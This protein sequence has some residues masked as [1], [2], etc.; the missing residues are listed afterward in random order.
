MSEKFI[1][2]RGGCVKGRIVTDGDEKHVYDVGG[3]RL[4]FTRNG[5]TYDGQGQLVD[6]YENAE[7][8][9]D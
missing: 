4:G 2:D 5:S 8:L 9:L 3:C 7:G 1:Y 6:S